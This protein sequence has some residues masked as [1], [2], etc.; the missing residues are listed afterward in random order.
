MSS[1][2]KN[3]P[4]EAEPTVMLCDRKGPRAR[5]EAAAS[6]EGAVYIAVVPDPAK[7]AAERSLGLHTDAVDALVDL[8]IEL[9]DNEETD[10]SGTPSR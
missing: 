8:M 3:R 7:L 2:R 5:S 10:G 9:A 6:S 1:R 4:A